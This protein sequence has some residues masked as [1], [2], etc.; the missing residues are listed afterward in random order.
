MGCHGQIWLTWLTLLDLLISALSISRLEMFP[1]G[2]SAGDELLDSGNDQT[3]EFVL[4]Q[5]LMFYDGKFNKIYV[6][7]C[8]PRLFY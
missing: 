2:P 7:W 3:R 1:Y 8:F 5:P 4:D 6:S